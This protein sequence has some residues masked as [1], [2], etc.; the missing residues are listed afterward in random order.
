MGSPAIAVEIK[1]CPKSGKR[2][3]ETEQEA[4]GFQ[5]KN[6]AQYGT[7]QQYVYLCEDC[8]RFHL[9]SQKPGDHG[10]TT[11][12]EKIA[13][14]MPARRKWARHYQLTR[15]EALQALDLNNK[16][17]SAHDLAVR[18][19][20]SMSQVYKALNEAKLNPPAIT[21]ESLESQEQELEAKLNRVREEKRRRLEAN[22][23]QIDRLP[24]GR[25]Q[26][27]KELQT[28]ILPTKECIN[29][30]TALEEILTAQA[31]A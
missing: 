10:T 24:D 31:A 26:I 29:L 23:I 30:V 5:A 12:Y 4:Q 22:R 20:T 28:L 8:N 13:N 19:G 6:S 1:K 17:T 9:T 3:F 2:I 18:F 16:G 21:V 25:I 14:A 7:G 11:N 27:K 15:A